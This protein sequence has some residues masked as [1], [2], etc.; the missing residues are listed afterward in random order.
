MILGEGKA[1]A[2]ERLF[3]SLG[4]LFRSGYDEFRRPQERSFDLRIRKRADRVAR[5]LGVAGRL[6]GGVFERT[7][8]VQDGQD[9]GVRDAIER[10]VAQDG[11]DLAAFGGGAVLQR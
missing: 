9:V 1:S 8:A 6:L 7:V 10:A 4:A 5:R 2:E 11:F 3:R